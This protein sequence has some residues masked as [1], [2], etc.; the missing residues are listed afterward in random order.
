[1]WAMEGEVTHELLSLGG[2]VLV[3]DNRYEMEF[4]VPVGVF[5]Y[6]ELQGSTPEEVGARLGRPAMLLRDHPDM[7]AVTW[8]LDRRNFR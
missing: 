3:H 1:M 4:L 2:R 7:S 8:P 6:V 5:R